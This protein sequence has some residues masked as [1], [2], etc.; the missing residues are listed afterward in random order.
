M[1]RTC[2]HFLSHFIS[3]LVISFP[4]DWLTRFFF[5]FCDTSLPVFFS[6]PWPLLSNLYLFLLALHDTFSPFLSSLTPAISS[7]CDFTWLPLS[8]DSSR[9][10]DIH[11]SFLFPRDFVCA[12]MCVFRLGG[13]STGMLNSVL[14][15][16][17]HLF[18]IFFF[19][20]YIFSSLMTKTNVAIEQSL[21]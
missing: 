9:C 11:A 13:H 12:C 19:L 15:K 17:Y 18:Q 2:F 6:S 14:L 7:A 4:W 3:D 20:I 5:G 21:K 16:H 10:L 8:Q 1:L